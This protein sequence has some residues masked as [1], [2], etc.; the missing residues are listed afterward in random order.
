[1][2][3][4]DFPASPTVGQIYTANG[5]SWK[6]D[7]V[8]WISAN[9]ITSI[10]VTGSTLTIYGS[11][12]AHPDATSMTFANSVTLTAA[13]TKTLTLNGGAGSNGL[14][15]DASNNVGIGTSSITALGSGYTTMAVQGTNGAG[16][17]LYA[18]STE[19]GRVYADSAGMILQAV[20][21][22][23]QLFL[24]NGAER[25]RI[26]TSGNLHVPGG[27]GIAS[28]EAFGTGA[29][30][31]NTTGSSNVA[32]GYQTL[33]ANTT[34]SSNT[35]IGSYA[36]FSN[37]T[38]YQNVAVG[39][40]SLELNTTGAQNTACGANA[41]LNN[42]GDNNSAFGTNALR[43]NTTGYQNTASGGS[44]LYNNTSGYSN[45][46]NGYYSLLNNSTGYNNFAGGSSAL[47]SNTTGNSNTASG[48]L[49][50]YSNTT[51]SNNT[52]SGASAL[53]NSTTG[54]YNTASGYQALFSNT[55]GISNTASG[56]QAL[57]VNTTGVYNNANGIGALFANTTGGYNTACGASALTTNTT[58]S[59]NVGI[60]Y[61][62]QAS[63]ATVNN[64]V[65]IYNGSV[66]AR[67]QG[68]AGSWSFVS[69]ARDKT[70][71]EPLTLGLDFVTGLQPRKFKW[72]IRNCDV[73]KG[74][75]ASGFIAQEVLEVI[76]VCN[77]EYTGLVDTNDPNQ[78]TLATG[79]LIPIL[80][81]A[82]K[83]LKAEI[84]TLKQKVNA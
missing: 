82:I 24:V 42:T 66:T 25:A 38:G 27:G 67:F 35:G 50:L 73:D 74:K 57:Y 69:D 56:F 43:L 62:A 18:G 75:E 48:Y 55:T 6:W 65:N 53:Q 29:L 63:S 23:P 34:G 76:Q 16:F 20:G 5:R 28:N 52:A 72:D 59:N 58:G 46:A 80:V 15:L 4:L 61:N 64:E 8:S 36:L 14:V 7:G 83:E 40:F 37:T 70:D 10:G 30:K 21:A 1:M 17:R 84:E 19:Y 41:L 79:N 51:G 45:T 60:G 49:A 31:S 3:A 33:N 12:I 11:P 71:I 47:Q 13:S 39:Y 2:A 32:V 9:Q 81:N 78:F 26:D 44:A 22:V 77:A 68:A 54:S